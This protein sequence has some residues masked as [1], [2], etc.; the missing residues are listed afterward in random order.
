M[1]FAEYE[2]QRDDGYRAIGHYFVAFSQLMH[3]LRGVIAWKLA[4]ASATNPNETFAE[5]ILGE[6]MPKLIIDSFFGMCR[7]VG[8]FDKT[9][10]L[11]ETRLR[12]EAIEAS[13][14]RND[15]AHG[16]WWV[17]LLSHHA[18]E[19]VR[20]PSLVRIKP[21][22][23][24]EHPEK[25]ENFSVRDL[26]RMADQLLLMANTLIEFGRLALALPIL[27][28]QDPPD[29]GTRVSRGE[30]RVRDVYAYEGSKQS[31]RVARTGAKADLVPIIE[32]VRMPDDELAE[33]LSS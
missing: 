20:D 4:D 13:I 22:R 1:K 5:M 14:K 25:V 2:Q 3:H 6:S 32:W 28:H 18:A 33:E 16:D 10:Q 17:G 23:V 26:D 12:N 31:G 21:G 27:R 7:L 15:I 29:T 11:I 30:F 8:D 9:E 24:G 19:K